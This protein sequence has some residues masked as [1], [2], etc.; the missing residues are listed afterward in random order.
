MGAQAQR[1]LSRGRSEQPHQLVESPGRHQDPLSFGQDPNS[2]Q[3]ANG[4]P[5]GVRGHQPQA[6]SLGHHQDPREDGPRVLARRRPGHLPQ[7][8]GEALNR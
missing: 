4:Q 7:G 3:I 2:P 8:V 1:H 5:V 6:L